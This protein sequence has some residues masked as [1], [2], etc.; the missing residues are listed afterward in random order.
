MDRRFS[1]VAVLLIL[2]AGA[3]YLWL[4]P[5]QSGTAQNGPIASAEAAPAPAPRRPAEHYI[6]AISWEPAFC[7]GASGKPECRSQRAG[8]ADATRLSLHGIWPDDDYCG[9]SDG[10]VKADKSGRWSDLPAVPLSA[11]TRADL[12]AAMPGTQS[13]LER[14]EWLK[15]GTCSGVE[16]DTYF[17]RATQFLDTINTSAVGQLLASR[18]GKSVDNDELRRAFDTAFGNGAGDRVRLACEQDGNRRIISE[19]TIGLR[20]DVM[21]SGGIAGLIAVAGR[22][23][24]GCSGGIVDPVGLQ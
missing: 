1:P 8:R 7:E 14:H 13:G 18:I 19:I 24:P 9:V 16:A 3:L 21:G 23:D 4:H 2:A 11:S 12:D 17:Q 6:L 22:T 15:H 10:L 5:E 20:G